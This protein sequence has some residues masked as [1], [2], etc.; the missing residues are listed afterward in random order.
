MWSRV[1]GGNPFISLSNVV[2]EEKL[3]K[4]IEELLKRL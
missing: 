3:D 4:E 1:V 2:L